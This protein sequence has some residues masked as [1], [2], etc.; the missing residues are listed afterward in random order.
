MLSKLSKIACLLIAI[1]LVA[2][3]SKNDPQAQHPV[4]FVTV[5]RSIN[6]DNALF[7]KLNTPGGYAYL[8]DEGYKGIIIT[9]DF[10][11]N[12]HAVD[13][14]CPFH[15]DTDCAQATVD[16]N[17]IRILCGAYVNDVFTPCCESKYGVDGSLLEGPSQHPLRA[18]A[19]QK[20]GSTLTITSF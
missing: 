5:N 1:G 7:T 17:G 14:A 4:P 15:P 13:R 6:M 16:K 2:S 12:F 9:R 11:D 3:C 10:A 8:N 18:Y 19:V 20:S